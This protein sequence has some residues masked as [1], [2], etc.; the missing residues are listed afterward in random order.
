M[1]VPVA[2]PGDR[3]VAQP[4]GPQAGL[5]R[6]GEA[7]RGAAVRDMIRDT[8]REPQAGQAT[9]GSSDLRTS[10]VSKVRSQVGQSYS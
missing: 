9:S 2:R 3:H 4:I 10:S 8:R 7:A 5:P 1:W 6:P